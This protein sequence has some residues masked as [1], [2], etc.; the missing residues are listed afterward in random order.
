MYI[1]LYID[2]GTYLLPCIYSGICPEIA[3]WSGFHS[4][5]EEKMLNI[6]ILQ[7]ARMIWSF[8]LR[9]TLQ[10]IHWIHVYVLIYSYFG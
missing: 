9:Y 8:E 10:D 3:Y 4:S 7:L 5:S 2:F 6:Q 1:R